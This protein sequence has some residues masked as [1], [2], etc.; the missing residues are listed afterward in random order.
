[1]DISKYQD[2]FS[3]KCMDTRLEEKND[4]IYVRAH[5]EVDE[6]IIP[7]N[8]KTQ[9]RLK[10][11]EFGIFVIFIDTICIIL[12]TAFALW[13]YFRQNQ[14]YQQ[15]K[16]QTIQMDDYSIKLMKIKTEDFEKFGYNY[17][18]L[19]AEVVAHFKRIFQ[20][21]AEDDAREHIEFEKLAKQTLNSSK[22]TSTVEDEEANNK[23]IQTMIDEKMKEYEIADITFALKND[24][25]TMLLQKMY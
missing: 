16:K 15:F 6:V 18:M 8:T 10:K 17:H 1:M 11:H 7:F 4:I 25:K 9:L 20:K 2:S 24:K 14:Y 22:R 5:C 23:K 19:K 3:Q 13:M 21:K 12:T